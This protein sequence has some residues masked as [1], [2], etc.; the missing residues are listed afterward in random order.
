MHTCH[1]T[2]L[3]PSQCYTL[4]CVISTQLFVSEF[5]LLLMS[6]HPGPPI[7]EGSTSLIWQNWPCLPSSCGCE[8]NPAPCEA[9]RRSPLPAVRPLA[10]YACGSSLK[11]ATKAEPSE[12]SR[13]L[14]EE[15]KQAITFLT[16]P[17]TRTT[18]YQTCSGISAILLAVSETL[19]HGACRAAGPASCCAVRSQMPSQHDH[20][21][22]AVAGHYEWTEG[23]ALTTRTL[24]GL[25]PLKGP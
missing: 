14:R 3:L 16:F 23:S 7:P 17:N 20:G 5:L 6:P 24:L 21:G 4:H 9:G 19:P 18:P 25:W 13:P 10:S 8:W 22:A 2:V 11:Q 12:E 15:T 1:F